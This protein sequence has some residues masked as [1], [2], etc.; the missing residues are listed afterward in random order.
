MCVVT[1]DSF[2][3]VTWLIHMCDMTQLYGLALRRSWSRL[4]H[5]SFIYVTWLIHMCDMTQLYGLALRRSWSRLWH[6][7]F[8]WVTWVI[9]MCD[10]TQLYGLALRRSWSRLW[11]ESFIYVTWVIHMCDMTHS[12]VW[13]DSFREECRARWACCGMCAPLRCASSYIYIYI[14]YIY[15]CIHIY[16]HICIYMYI[17][18][19][20]YTYM[21]EACLAVYIYH[22]WLDWSLYDMPKKKMKFPSYIFPF[23]I[24]HS[25]THIFTVHI[26]AYIYIDMYKFIQMYT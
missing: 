8:I 10:M 18:I 19:Y 24:N 9:H 12:C 4:W 26:Y 13:H 2:I 6:E 5:E 20:M 23:Y 14:L 15:I 1:R 7:S 25:C 21:Y 16:I 17:Y 22:I 3:C 11:H